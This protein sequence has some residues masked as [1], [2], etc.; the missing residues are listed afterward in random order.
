MSL[1]L[2]GPFVFKSHI[3]VSTTHLPHSPRRNSFKSPLKMSDG[4]PS[5]KEAMLLGLHVA[6][7]RWLLVIEGPLANSRGA[8]QGSAPALEEEMRILLS[9]IAD[10]LGQDL[11][12]LAQIWA[13]RGTCQADFLD[14]VK[15]ATRDGGHNLDFILEQFSTSEV[16]PLPVLP[17]HPSDAEQVICSYLEEIRPALERYLARDTPLNLW[18]AGTT[19]EHTEFLNSL[20]MPISRT[21]SGGPDMVLHNLGAFERDK[22]FLALLE[23][24]FPYGSDMTETNSVLL[25]TSGSGK[26]RTML[27]GLCLHW[28]IYLTCL[29]DSEGRGSADLQ[30]TIGERIARNSDFEHDLRHVQDLK[31]AAA[32]NSDIAQNRFTEVLLA[33][34]CI[35]NFFCKLAGQ[36]PSG[37]TAEHRKLWVYLQVRP[38][39]LSAETRYSD[40]FDSLTDKIKGVGGNEC[41]L[42]IREILLEL[43]QTLDK[44][45]LFCVIDEAQAAATSLK[46]AFFTSEERGD[47]F[48]PALRELVLSF[49]F[50]RLSLTITGTAIDKADIDQILASRTFKDLNPKTMTHCGTFSSPSEQI[51]YMQQFLPPH[52]AA[53]KSYQILF[54]RVTYWLKG[55]YRFTAAYMR[56]LLLNDFQLPHLTLNKYISTNTS[57]KIQGSLSTSRGFQP[58]DFEEEWEDGTVVL[59]TDLATFNFEKLKK[60]PTLENLIREHAAEYCMRSEINPIV[61]DEAHFGLVTCGFGR[62]TANIEGDNDVKIALDEPLVLLALGEWLQVDGLPLAESLRMSAAKAVHEARGAN[63]LEEYLA[64]YLSAVFDDK[65]P[66]TQIFKFHEDIDPPEWATRPA[67]LV[68]LYADT[69]EG[70]KLYDGRVS[71][72]CRPSATIGKSASRMGETRAWLEHND[73]APICFPRRMD[74]SRYTVHFESAR[75]VKF[76]DLGRVAVEIRH[77]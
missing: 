39:C 27:E 59:K 7:Q 8:I 50:K 14:Q 10:P 60:N 57:F 31:S 72:G 64:L 26:T 9:L 19:G 58:T 29:V 70:G 77:R 52:L 30:T 56:E 65:T 21:R 13:A 66:L 36:S 43:T 35:M 23:K 63:G 12:T 5:E 28:G 44:K 68:S 69:Q 76:S 55:R 3:R 22:K 42:M 11:T 71:H 20:K 34:L 2:G 54:K 47:K 51:A 48:R 1:F 6:L 25:N 67:T 41:L 4:N 46:E 33:R 16:N 40:I 61:A 18:M 53:T 73:R 74:G 17:V 62:Y 75:S 32:S 15:T 49:T 45:V 38:S 24:L 37:L